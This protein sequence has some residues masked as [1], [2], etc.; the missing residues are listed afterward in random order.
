MAPKRPFSPSLPSSTSPLSHPTNTTPAI[1]RSPSLHDRSSRFQALYS[2]ILPPFHLQALPELASATHRITAWRFPSTQ[3]A[4]PSS[5]ASRQER[6]ETGHDDDGETHGGRA[7][8]AV[9][10]EKNVTGVV[11]VARWYGGRMLGPV[12]FEHIKNCA[13]DAIAGSLHQASSTQQDSKRAKTMAAGAVEGEKK[14]RRRE[15]VLRI[16]AERD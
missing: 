14:K 15:E 16:L 3:R 11:V 6:Y 8:E 7:L 13:R 9:L 10:A 12:R 2:P 5:S 1:H 4:L